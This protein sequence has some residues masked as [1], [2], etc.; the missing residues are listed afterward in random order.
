MPISLEW[1]AGFF[2]GEGSITVVHSISKKHKQY[3]LSVGLTQSNFDVLDKIRREYGGNLYKKSKQTGRHQGYELRWTSKAAIEFLSILAP[4][5]VVKKPQAEIALGE[6]APLLL[7]R[8]R[9]GPGQG[10]T[11][12]DLLNRENVRLKLHFLNSPPLN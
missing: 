10:L 6:W 7:P 1:L 11:D 4:Y 5:L 2:D 3:F 8:G 12:V 9:R